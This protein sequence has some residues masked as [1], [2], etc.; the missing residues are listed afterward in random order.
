MANTNNKYYEQA[1]NQV[2][3]THNA[4]VNA[5]KNQLAQNQLNL[6]QQKTG[7]N[8]N[9]DSQVDRQNLNNRLNKNNVSNAI[10][11]RGLGNSSIAVSGLAEQD[12]RNT[13]MIGDINNSRT[14]DLNNIDQ[15]KALLAQNMNNTLAQ[16]EIDKEKQIQNLAMQL[17]DRQWDKDFKEKGFQLQQQAQ[18]Y[19]QQ[20]KDA[21]LKMQQEKQKFDMGYQ[22][23][24]L[25]MQKQAQQAEANYKNSLLALQREEMASNNSYKQQQLALQQQAQAF[26]QQRYNDSL[27]AN[28]NSG[29]NKYSDTLGSIIGGNYSAKE[30]Y[31]LLTGLYNQVDLYGQ[32]NGI[33]TQP[34]RDNIMTQ[35][36]RIMA[37]NR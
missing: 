8:A 37:Q 12:A 31:G 11:G 26:E 14:A 35:Y 10:L 1:K 20:Y 15:Q 30:K 5:L 2:S 7:I 19:E 34:L 17:E 4:S 21:M 25:A 13:R 28:K 36:K 23:E 22:N 33:D 24:Y 18:A 6:E 27:N 3:V 29:L 9:Y 32:N 16:M